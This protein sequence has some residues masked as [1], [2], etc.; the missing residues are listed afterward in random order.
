[1]GAVR[2]LV[3]TVLA[4]LAVGC[5]D[6]EIQL[7]SLDPIEQPDDGLAPIDPAACGFED[8][9]FGG[10]GH[11][12]ETELAPPEGGR[13]FVVEQFTDFSALAGEEQIEMFEG[14]RAALLRSN[15]AGDP[16]TVAVLTTVPFVPNH[17]VFVMDQLSEVGADG[18]AL[19]VRVLGDDGAVLEERDLAVHTGGYV[20]ALLDEHDPI[21]GAPWIDQD[22]GRE[23]EF[24]RTLLDV[25][26][27]FDSGETIQLQFRQHTLIEHNG[28]F[29][30]LDN[31]CDGEPT[32]P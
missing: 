22:S 7:P 20:P 25:A 14:E 2:A 4:L 1:M 29:T 21:P 19:S 26:E 11:P 16:A 27:W 28:F 32:Q 5:S 17:R 24:T 30:L 8:G 13:V 10:F 31:L 23:G 3:P 18:V 12:G 9:D 6:L 15:D